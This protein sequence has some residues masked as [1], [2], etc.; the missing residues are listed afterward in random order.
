MGFPDR[1]GGKIICGL[2]IYYHYIYCRGQYGP[3]CGYSA[4][5]CPAGKANGLAA[6]TEFCSCRSAEERDYADLYCIFMNKQDPQGTA[7]PG[8]EVRI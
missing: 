2:F 8:R 1:S 7:V 4:S 5:G 6:F 3:V